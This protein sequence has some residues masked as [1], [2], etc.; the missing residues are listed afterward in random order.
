MAYIYSVSYCTDKNIH[1][2]IHCK[3]VCMS[4]EKKKKKKN[5]QKRAWSQVTNITSNDA[6]SG[7]Q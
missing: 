6:K 1:K 5:A 2:W 4:K 3:Y 7:L